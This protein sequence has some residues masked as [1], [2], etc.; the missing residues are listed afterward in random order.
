MTIADLRSSD[1]LRFRSRKGSLPKGIG[2]M[3]TVMDVRDILVV[4]RK[5]SLPKGIGRMVSLVFPS[6]AAGWGREFFWKKPFARLQAKG[7]WALSES[8]FA[9]RTNNPEKP[10]HC[11]FLIFN[12]G[13]PCPPRNTGSQRD[14]HGKAH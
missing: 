8:L 5:G 12:E 3:V 13:L 2:D 6:P 4:S 11:S 7:K 14:P 1:N 9:F 10:S